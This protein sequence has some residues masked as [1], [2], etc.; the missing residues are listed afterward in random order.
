MA[1]SVQLFFIDSWDGESLSL[2]ADGNTIYQESYTV[3]ESSYNDTCGNSD[4]D[5]ILTIAS[6]P[7]SHTAST[8]TLNFTTTLDEAGSE[9][10]FGFN[11]IYITLDLCDSACIACT[12]SAI[13]ECTACNSGWFLSGTTCGTTCPTGY[14]GNLLTNTC[15]GDFFK[16]N[17]T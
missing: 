4:P 8:L 10:S 11:E 6:N 17:L 7:F 12:G 3:N 14:Y 16:D 2:I 5:K 9:E 15:T 1:V 13:S